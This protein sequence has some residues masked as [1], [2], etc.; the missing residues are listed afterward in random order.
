[1]VAKI[2]MKFRMEEVSEAKY[3]ARQGFIFGKLRFILV[4][5]IGGYIHCTWFISYVS[6][7]VKSV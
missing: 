7:N 4:F 5:Y 3:L 2:S 6:Y 1:M